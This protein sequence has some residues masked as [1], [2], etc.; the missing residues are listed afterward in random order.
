MIIGHQKQ[1]ALLKKRAETDKLSHAYLFTGE[2]K[3]G[4]KKVA[5]ELGPLL[6]EQSELSLIEP[7]STGVIEINQIRELIWKLSLKPF[8]SV[9]VP[10]IAVIDNAHL[11]TQEAQSALLKILEE[12][13]GKT[14]FILITEFPEVLFPTILSRVQKIKFFPVKKEEIKEYLIK[15]GLKE[16]AAEEVG[17]FSNGK[18]GLAISLLLDPEKLK[19][20]KKIIKELMALSQTN[21]SFRFQYAKELSEKENIKEILDIWLRYFRKEIY[22]FSN[23]IKQIQNINFL[24][25]TTNA[26]IRLALETLMLEL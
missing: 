2:E 14:L 15:K 16:G 20:Q 17:E 26:N 18:P 13:R 5:L 8:I 23:L 3:I 7:L 12:P 11:M 9:P 19:N 24:I 10:K 22:K 21:L 25:L 1:I 6:F 4:K